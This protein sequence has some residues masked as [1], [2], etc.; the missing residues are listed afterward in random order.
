MEE[1]LSLS[2]D[3]L[4]DEVTLGIWLQSKGRGIKC[5]EV[6]VACNTLVSQCHCVESHG[7][8]NITRQVNETEVFQSV[9]YRGG[10][11]WGVWG[12]QTPSEIPKISVESS[13]AWAR[14]TGVSISFCSSLFS[15]T[16]VT[17]YIKVSFNTNCLAVAYLVSEFKP[18]PTSRKFDKVEPDCKFSV[19]WWVFL[20]QH[21]N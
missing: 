14:R 15:H 11:V 4:L 12:V 1:A 20:F 18:T 10:G 6:V 21:P 8:Q 7:G 13:I 2:Q 9:A 5:M 19:K 16:V 3:G 17:Y